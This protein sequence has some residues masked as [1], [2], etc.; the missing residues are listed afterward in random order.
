MSYH[1]K[2]RALVLD[3]T[4]KRTFLNKVSHAYIYNLTISEELEA[5]RY[6]N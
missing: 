2:L 6:F 4:L 1:H 5:K 3:E